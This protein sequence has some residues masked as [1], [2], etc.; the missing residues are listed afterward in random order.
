MDDLLQEERLHLAAVGDE[1]EEL[2]E[3]RWVYCKCSICGWCIYYA[4]W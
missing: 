2:C 3:D 1:E 4:L